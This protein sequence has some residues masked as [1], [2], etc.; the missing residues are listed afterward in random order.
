MVYKR[1]IIIMFID[2]F[3]DW[4]VFNV[5]FMWFMVIIGVSGMVGMFTFIIIYK[6]V[7]SIIRKPRH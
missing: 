3:Y 6:M 1:E 5:D 4:V 7:M 2:V